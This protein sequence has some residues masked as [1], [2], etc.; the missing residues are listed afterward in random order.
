ME[1]QFPVQQAI[2]GRRTIKKFKPDAIPMET[3]TALLDTAIWAPNHKMREP[4]RFIIITGD[5]RNSFVNILK[6]ESMKGRDAVPM[7]EAKIQ[8]WLSIPAYVV[9]VQ[10]QDPRPLIDEEDFAAVSALIQN[11]QLAAWEQG[12]GTL[13]N[14]NKHIYNPVL[15]EAIGV[16]AGEKIV[17]VLQ[18]GYPAHVPAAMERTPVADKLTILSTSF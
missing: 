10:Q 8:H 7:K 6:E 17:G 2:R 1:Q 14:T 15:R 16:T 4:W 9:V 5:A 12:I 11:F 13:W 3:L 18:T